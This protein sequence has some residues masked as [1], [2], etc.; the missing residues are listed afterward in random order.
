[1]NHNENDRRPTS[2]EPEEKRLDEYL[3][4][5]AGQIDVPAEFQSELERRILAAHPPRPA[6]SASFMKRLAPALAWGIALV[7]LALAL[8]WAI[9]SLVPAPIPAEE[10]RSAPTSQPGTTPVDSG[11]RS[12]AAT[13]AANETRYD[14]RGT[15][16]ILSQPLPDSA[17]EAGVFELQ[18]G[19]P[20]SPEQALALAARF[21]IHGQAYQAPATQPG[22]P[23]YVVT[24]GRQWISVYSD[25]SF[26][27]YADYQ[28]YQA[29][30]DHKIDTQAATA[31]IDRFLKS[32]G[33]DFDYRIDA[34]DM[35]GNYFVTPLTPDVFAVHHE[36]LH[37]A[38]LQITLDEAGEV[39]AVSANLVA[40]RQTRSG[41][42]LRTAQEAFEMILN[43]DTPAGLIESFYSPSGPSRIWQRSYPLEQAVTIHGYVQS[44]PSLQAGQP[45][46][47]HIDPYLTGGNVDGLEAIPA[48]SFVEASGRFVVDN[49]IEKFQVESWKISAAAQDG[50]IGTLERDGA[51]VTLSAQEGAYLLNDVPPDLPLPLE[52]AFVLGVRAGDVFDWTSIDD[53]GR[54][55]GGGG[56]GGGG[57]GFYKLNLSGT[58][59][60]LPPIPTPGP[61]ILPPDQ[62]PTGGRIDG[63]RGILTISI[64]ESSR[65]VQYNLVVRNGDGEYPY[66]ILEGDLAALQANANRPV[67]IWGSVVRFDQNASPVVKVDRYE[68]PFPG[69]KFQV[70]KGTQKN[71]ELEG[72]PATL[73]TAQDGRTFV[74]LLPDG[75]PDVFQ[76]L[77]GR[78][79]DSILLAG[80]L[81]PG[82]TDAGYPAMRVSS[83]QM[84]VN[85]KTGE[86]TDVSQMTAQFD[87]P[88]IV[89]EPQSPPGDQPAP[90]T[91]TVEKI[92]LVYYLRE[93]RT[94]LP[95]QDGSPA[96]IQPAW[97]FYGHYSSGEEF[98]IL[99]QALKDEYLLPELAPFTPPG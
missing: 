5:I 80:L 70:L 53:R 45:P 77:I 9:R 59:V 2:L 74:Q 57:A 51:R 41:F 17:A 86:E 13:P 24:D 15:T 6:G 75:S 46:L 8:D 88:S 27:Y 16:L 65:Q 20:D 29:L 79:G 40:Y 10:N 93:A 72:R 94:S 91:A 64:F 90:P 23:N 60:P 50:F 98:E 58:P 52:N 55:A 35:W 84:A 38:G 18:P 11:V 14:W 25:L 95:E 66:L 73:F 37:P 78:E 22:G 19:Q 39:A 61:T 7:L 33:F 36:D 92:E 97:R 99:V 82:E 87:Q 30:T 89:P 42:G 34:T 68:V 1:M 62:R 76:S 81:I 3:Q 21:G 12:V 47:I 48:N 43:P 96:T 54:F 31:A 26:T 49:G 28:K 4:K 71:V 44:L 85:P 56:G 63:L 83:G 67:D 69:L 32:R